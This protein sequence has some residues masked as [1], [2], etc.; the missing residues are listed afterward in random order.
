VVLLVSAVR[1]E[2]GDHPG[3]PLGVGPVVTA[4]R[5]AAILAEHKPLAVIMVGTAGAY[6]QDLA[7]G[8]AVVAERVGLSEGVAA[9][10]LGYVPRAPKPIACDPQLMDRLKGA[11]VSVLTVSAITTDAILAG[12]LADGWQIEQ[13]EAYG[14]AVACAQANV[15]FAAVYGIS[16]TVG[17]NAHAQWLAFRH[18]AQRQA[19][20]VVA[21]LL[22]DPPRS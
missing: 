5:L 22:N 4:A 20:R 7:V 8:S 14:A 19:L 12:R 1:E 18:E 9:M 21:P 10:G 3:E 6:S 2:M 13:M 11:R 17:P 15:P 16:N